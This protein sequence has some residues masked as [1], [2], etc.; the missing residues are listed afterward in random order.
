MLRVGRQPDSGVTLIEMLVMLALFAVLA[1]VVTIAM[2]GG[3]DLDRADLAAQSLAVAL[4]RAVDHA[5]VSGRGFGLTLSA[6]GLQFVHSD[7][8][9]EWHPHPDPNLEK[10]KLSP[11][12]PR[13]SNRAEQSVVFSVSKALVPTG[14][15]P[16]VATFGS[17][18]AA[19]TVIFDGV[20]A[21][22]TRGNGK[23]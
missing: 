21:R 22:V 14:L 17:G 1:G 5:L 19:H 23:Q 9:G 20:N 7:E 15:K 13:I 4:H 16:F 18:Q 2:P 6:E 11:D 3:R 8:D 12:T 10:V